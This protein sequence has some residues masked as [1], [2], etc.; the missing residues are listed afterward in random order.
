MHGDR[1]KT[2]DSMYD[3]ACLLHEQ[4]QTATALDLL[5][6]I[7]SMAETLDMGEGQAARAEWRA[8]RILEGKGR[9]EESRRQLENAMLLRRKARPGENTVAE[10][11]SWETLVPFML[12]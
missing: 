7:V 11:G 1:F 4:G 2:C 8:S 12:W 6:G 5:I 10:E 3:V 9:M